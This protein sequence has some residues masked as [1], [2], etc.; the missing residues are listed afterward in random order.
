VY[1]G[2][3]FGDASVAA[4]NPAEHIRPSLAQPPPTDQATVVIPNSVSHGLTD[5][6]KV[7]VDFGLGMSASLLSC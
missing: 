1:G 2:N 5:P 3:E 4:R 6:K 7:F